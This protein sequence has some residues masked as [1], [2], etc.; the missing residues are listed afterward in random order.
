VE[1]QDINETRAI[2]NLAEQVYITF[3]RTYTTKCALGPQK[4][5][6]G[7]CP[8]QDVHFEYSGVNQ[9]SPVRNDFRHVDKAADGLSVQ[10]QNKR[11]A[12]RNK[13]R[14]DLFTEEE[15]AADNAKHADYQQRVGLPVK[16]FKK[17]ASKA[18]MSKA[19]IDAAVRDFQR[20]TRLAKRAGR[21]A[22]VPAEHLK[23]VKKA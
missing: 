18:G 6:A 9:A 10:E 21:P 7:L 5:L 19:A 17:Q 13:E 3:L 11:H 14:R 16:R 4:D 15:E 22:P 23:V 12:E 20:V 8:Y 1:A 2:I